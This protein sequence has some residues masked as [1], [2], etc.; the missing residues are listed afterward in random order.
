MQSKVSCLRKQHGGK[1]QASGHRPPDV[2][3]KAL[4]TRSPTHLVDVVFL[5]SE[6]LEG[7]LTAMI[8]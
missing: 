6:G 2:I 3:S 5:F 7:F 4:T 1:D 8:F